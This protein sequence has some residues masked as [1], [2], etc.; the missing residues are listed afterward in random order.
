MTTTPNPA[1]T[2][3]SAPAQLVV[4]FSQAVNFSTVTAADLTFTKLPAGVASVTVGTPIAVDDPT[5]PTMVAF[6]LSY[7]LKP[8]QTANGTYN[9]T[10][11]GPIVSADS[12]TLTPFTTGSFN[13]LDVTP[14]HVIGVN[15]KGRVVS[16]QFD[17][18]LAP[19]L[20]NNTVYVA[21]TDAQGNILANLDNNP[22]FKMS[23]N[24]VTNTVVL[25]YKRPAA[26]GAAVRLL[27]DRRQVHRDPARRGGPAG[28]RGHLGH[29][30]RRHLLRRLPERL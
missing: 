11:D 30:P 28:H 10:V 29:P 19:T 27:Q 23:W 17:K 6:P 21:L 5:N 16:I 13:V 8:G 4:T 12:K 25:D 14:P 22:Q 26:D 9:Y 1:A 18:A 3:G 24:A 2:V 7:V 15:I 20:N